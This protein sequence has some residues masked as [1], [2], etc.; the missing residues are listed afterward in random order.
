MVFSFTA[1]VATD[2][3]LRIGLPQLEQG[4]FAT[5]VIPT[6]TAA[7]TRAADVAV[8]TG[9]NFSNW[10]LQSEGSF[11]VEWIAGQR[12]DF[13]NPF[14]VGST[15]VNGGF[16]NI[17][18]S[19]TGNVVTGVVDGTV[20]QAGMPIITGATVAGTTYKG[21]LAYQVDNFAGVANGGAVATDTLGT[22]PSTIGTLVIGNGW[23]NTVAG[24]AGNEYLSG[25]I[26]RLAFF[27]RRLADAELQ[28]I[29]A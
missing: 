3:T 5:S 16:M 10:Y 23:N 7:A 8:M 26:R 4:A 22:V 21:A 25:H 19:A 11:L 18:R 15:V 2:I 14:S 1:G 24:L 28:G 6:T 29:T 17:R 12:T 9:A 20:V 27:P 13:I